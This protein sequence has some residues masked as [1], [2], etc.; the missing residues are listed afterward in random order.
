MWLTGLVAPRHV[1]SSQT[2]A[3]TRVP[4]IGRQILNHCATRE[5]PLY[6]FYFCFMYWNYVIGCIKFMADISIYKY[7][8]V[9]ISY[10]FWYIFSVN[11]IFYQYELSLPPSS[12]SYFFPL[13]SILFDIITTLPT[14]FLLI[15]ACHNYFHPLTFNL[16]L[17]FCF[18]CILQ[19]AYRLLFFKSNLTVSVIQ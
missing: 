4:C 2:R 14:L 1:G 10:I 7:I 12:F 3:R 19:A 18:R 16:P 11:V 15:F 6:N 8:F 9:D 17:S 5:A 13:S